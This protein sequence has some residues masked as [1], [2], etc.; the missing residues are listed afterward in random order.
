MQSNWFFAPYKLNDTV[1]EL[2]L[3]P[4][5][6]VIGSEL[7]T[8][9]MSFN[10][11]MNGVFVSKSYDDGEGFLKK[12]RNTNDLLVLTSFQTGTDPTVDRIHL[13]QPK[14]EY[15]QWVGDFFKSLV[16][17]F[18]DFKSS[19]VTIRTRVH[20]IDDFDKYKET[21]TSVSEAS[22]SI[23]V[24]FPVIAPFAAV[25]LPAIKGIVN[26][27]DS[28]DD[29]ESIIDSNLQLSI[30]EENTGAKILQTGHWIYFNKPQDEGLKLNPTL[31]V[32]DRNNKS[33]ELFKECDYVVYSIMA[34]EAQEPEW[35]TDQK[36]AKLLS[37]LGGKGN[38]GKSAVE[39][40]RD[41][42]EGY[43]K[44]KKLNRI[45]ELEE[46]ADKTEVEKALLEKL[47]ADKSIEPFLPKTS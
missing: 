17:S 16:C 47:K 42:V 5:K 13:Y 41:T 46:K 34:E 19:N 9:A 10:I 21:L 1:T 14:L 43:S 3:S 20:D 27:I 4:T 28:L 31:Q 11:R 24:T 2:I 22:G 40:V 37:E 30:S 32:L 33:N 6:L 8:K 23:S 15:G 36:V 18:S 25:A 12:R 29:H 7:I 38:S 45:K 35:E 44:F 39:F 26:M